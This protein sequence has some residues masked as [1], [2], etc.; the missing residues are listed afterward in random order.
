VVLAV[1]AALA[2]CSSSP[3]AISQA[4]KATPTTGKVAGAPSPT[5]AATG[6]PA[7]SGQL[8]TPTG[9][10]GTSTG[11]IVDYRKALGTT[12]DDYQSAWV[13]YLADCPN[14]AGSDTC[15][16]DLV[17]VNLQSGLIV[18]DLENAYM[19]NSPVYVGLPPAQIA[20]IVARTHADARRTAADSDPEKVDTAGLATA[21]AALNVDANTLRT[22]LG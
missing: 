21:G 14:G 2:G 10:V 12:L 15:Q 7:T 5:P 8:P 17:V 19:A 20:D 11:T 16:Q 13:K 18:L 22:A 6:Q 9:A 3:P 4:A 1:A